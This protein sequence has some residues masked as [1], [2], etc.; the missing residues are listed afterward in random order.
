MK[1]EI[2]SAFF[3]TRR[4]KILNGAYLH[5]SQGE[6]VGLLGRNGS[7]KTTLYKLIFGL[8]PNNDVSK[9]VDGQY[10]QSLTKSGILQYQTEQPSIP[11][12]LTVEK[13]MN[14][15]LDDLLLNAE[16]LELIDEPALKPLRSLS[17]GKRKYLESL[18]L[19]YSSA[20]FL[21]MDEPFNG[22]SPLMVEHLSEIMVRVKE[23]KGI[24]ITDHRYSDVA[25]I[26]DRLVLMHQGTLR[27]INKKEDLIRLGYLSD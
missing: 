3:E 26:T 15:F 5:I 14:L 4:Q 19:L 24:V 25:R 21:L 22:L 20:P 1:L 18:I 2:D 7:G 10:I 17:Q 23:R 8:I 11:S 12:H 9:R 27:D 16:L 13:A 6:I